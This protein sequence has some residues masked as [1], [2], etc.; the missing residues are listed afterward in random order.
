MGI[1]AS[2]VKE[3]RDKTGAGMMDCK[4]ALEET[5]GDLEKAVQLLREKGIAA[6]DHKAGRVALEGL[7][8]AYIHHGNRVGALIEVNCET[9]FVARTEEFGR[10]V[11]DLAM[12]VAAT[13]PRW[14]RRE[15]VPADILDAERDLLRQQALA[16]GKPE[17][18]VDRIVEGRLNKFLSD[19]CLEEQ[20]FIRD[21]D[22]TI[23]DLVRETVARVGENVRI[24][25]FARFELGAHEA[26]E[27]DT[28]E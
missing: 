11:K 19:V 12:Q 8:E 1:T 4:R 2:Q 20:A 21:S 10:F 7:V 17:H 14:V 6:A 13:N 5:K 15:E 28:E 16:E 26:Q 24:S 25:R 27:P 22:Q 18:I 3:L 9:D 23:G